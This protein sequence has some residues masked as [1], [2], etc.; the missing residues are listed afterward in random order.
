[1]ISQFIKLKSAG[2]S[3]TSTIYLQ[4]LYQQSAGFSLKVLP[5]T[6]IGENN[7]LDH[8]FKFKLISE[9]IQ[10]NILMTRRKTLND[11]APENTKDLI[12]IRQPE[13]NWRKV[14]PKLPSP[15]TTIKW[16]IEPYH[17]QPRNCGTVF[18]IE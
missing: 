18:Q 6:A 13:C 3:H 15:V 9:R 11:P 12:P 7:V 4:I 10:F 5:D 17:M 2:L 14:L 16:L 8:H 1:M